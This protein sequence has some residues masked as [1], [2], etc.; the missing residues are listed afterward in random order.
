MAGHHCRDITRN[1]AKCIAQ[2]GPTAFDLR[3]I[4]Q[5]LADHIVI[6]KMIYKT[7]AFTRFKT[8]EK[9]MSECVIEIITQEQFITNPY[10]CDACDWGFSD[11]RSFINRPTNV[12][13][14]KS[15]TIVQCSACHS[16]SDF[17]FTCFIVENVY[18]HVCI[19]K[20]IFI[21]KSFS[22][23]NLFLLTNFQRLSTV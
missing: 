11:T 9:K 1:E 13:G 16:I 20:H 17:T 14:S 19:S 5:K 3:A 21:V 15:E 2:R 7:T 23:R 4:S 18:S 10:Q 22:L 12:I 6:D 8:K